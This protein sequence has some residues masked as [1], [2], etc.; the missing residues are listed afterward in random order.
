MVFDFDKAGV[1]VTMSYQSRFKD[2]VC[3]ESVLRKP[4]CRY[5]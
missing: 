5:L 4:S 2:E 1:Q 3:D